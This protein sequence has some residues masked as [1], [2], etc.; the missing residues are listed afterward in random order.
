MYQRESVTACRTTQR[1]M[2]QS[3]NAIGGPLEVE[4]DLIFHLLTVENFL[5]IIYLTA[6][7]VKKIVN[8]TLSQ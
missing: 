4:I 3:V 6:F 1:K 8:K 2:N 5:Q 7:K